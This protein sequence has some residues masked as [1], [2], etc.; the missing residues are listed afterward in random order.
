MCEKRQ[1]HGYY[2]NSCGE[3]MKPT[4][5]R[6]LGLIGS[7]VLLIGG[8]FRALLATI[9]EVNKYVPTHWMIWMVAGFVL[10]NLIMMPIT[11]L[12]FGLAPIVILL[13]PTS[14]YNQ[15]VETRSLN[16]IHMM[17]MYGITI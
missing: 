2:C 8:S 17:K 9:P 13:A 10:T 4:L 16:A 1:E 3:I 12:S 5:K 14:L 15:I 11:I 6:R 7:F